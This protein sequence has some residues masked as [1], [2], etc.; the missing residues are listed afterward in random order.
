METRLFWIG[1][2]MGGYALATRWGRNAGWLTGRNAVA[3]WHALFFALSG[4]ALALVAAL[5]LESRLNLG[6]AGGALSAKE[7]LLAAGGALILGAYGFWRAYANGGK[8]E[9]RRHYLSEDLEWAETVFSA[10]IL[11]TVMMYFIVQ[12]FK[13]PSASMETT[14]RVG[15]HL[16]VNKFLY[17]V[18]LPL[19][20]VRF[21]RLREVRRGDIIVFRFPTD[22]PDEEHCGSGQ[23]GKDFIK[24]VI[25]LPGEV[26]ELQDGK[27]F[28]DGKPLER[29]PYALYVPGQ[30]R[31]PRPGV[32]LSLEQYQTL[33]VERKLDKRLGDAMRDNFGPVTVPKDS[34]LVLGDNRDHSCDSRFWGPVPE[35]YLKGKAW[36]I[37]WPPSRMGR[38]R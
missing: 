18:R 26:V 19:T 34:Y 36:V 7:L 12:A 2:A 6:S 27:V 22:D 28:I 5:S 24:R 4:F 37:Y 13:I 20:D 21:L 29:E 23:Y 38:I 33:W 35:R 10:V 17:G 8:A 16:F 25:G 14:L 31:V 1:V 32:P 15:D 9:A 30:A 11:A 3:G